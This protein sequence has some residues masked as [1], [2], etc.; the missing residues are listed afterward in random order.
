MAENNNA[1][2]AIA[3]LMLDS[4]SDDSS[5]TDSDEELINAVQIIRDK[6]PRIQNYIEVITL[7]DDKEFKS[8]FR[9]VCT[10]FDVGRATAWRCVLRVTKA[11]YMLRNTFI[12]W[13]TRQQAEVTSTKIEERSGFPNV[14]GAVDGTLIKISAP[15]RN[16]EAY[17][18]RKNYCAI[19]LQVVCDADLRF[20]HCYAGQ[21]GSVHDMRTF[22]Y[23]G[24]Q[25]KCNPQ[26]F[27]GDNHLLGDAAYTIQRHV[28]V[29]YRNN[30]HLTEASR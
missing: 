25:Q 22:M 27:Y 26:F 13:P 8:H 7:Y 21:P 24:L 16:P 18:C 10:K 29:P 1:L 3:I 19:Q 2:I 6:R 12:V 11:L 20:I 14:I 23:S 15:K 5:S 28:M 17:I 9:S 30:G 4:S